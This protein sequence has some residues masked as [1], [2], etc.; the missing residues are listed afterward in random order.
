MHSALLL[1]VNYL[2]HVYAYNGSDCPFAKTQCAILELFRVALKQSS[3]RIKLTTIVNLRD[4]DRVG[5]AV[6][7]LIILSVFALFLPACVVG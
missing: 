2:S 5:L 4:S 6:L 7:E 1:I 3:T